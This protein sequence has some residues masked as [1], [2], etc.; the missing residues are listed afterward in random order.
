MISTDYE[1]E[2]QGLPGLTELVVIESLLSTGRGYHPSEGSNDS[3]Q[4]GGRKAYNSS[5]KRLD[6]RLDQR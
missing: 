3:W 1:R 5:Q 6:K 2:Y 4:N